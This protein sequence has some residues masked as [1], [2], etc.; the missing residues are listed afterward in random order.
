GVS[1][2]TVSRVLNTPNL[3]AEETA[4]KVRK[5]V[6]ELKYKPNLFAKGLMTRK[7]QVL[8]IALPDLHGEF[9]ST[10]LHGAD[11]EARRHGY[12][13]LVST[14]ARRNGGG[15]G[16][17][18]EASQGAAQLDLTFGIVEGIALMIT[19]P[20]D[21]LVR[22]AMATGL[23]L[24]VMDSEVRA[25]TVD[26]VLVDNVVGTVEAVAHLAEKTPKDRI[27]FVGGPEGNFDTR[28]RAEAFTT[29][30]KGFGR[31]PGP[32]QLA[33]KEYSEAWGYEWAQQ[34]SREGGSSAGGRLKGSAVLCANDEIAVGVLQAAE[35]LGL[36][37]GP[38][39]EGGGGVRIVGFDDTRIASIVRPK[40]S[41]VRVPLIEVGA[42]SVRLLLQR[43]E[44]PDAPAHVLRL[45]TRL[46]VRQSS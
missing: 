14:D 37:V 4:G 6:A 18:G 26:C 43:I 11:D 24:V 39:D 44:E 32:M 46:V 9:Y 8:G 33:Y 20:Q 10:L 21:E 31:A 17:E 27:Y 42:A 15:S 45:P 22:R 38:G 12:Q 5:A 19:Q 28:M 35:D 16:E 7:S 41:S 2:A 25:P 3:V 40:L 29:T 36:R 13:L 30:L 1:T 23:P 34:M